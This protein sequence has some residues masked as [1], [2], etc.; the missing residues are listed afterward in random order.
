[1]TVKH[2]IHIRIRRVAVW[3]LDKCQYLQFGYG[4][5]Y[6]PDDTLRY[7]EWLWE[8][9]AANPPVPTRAERW[10]LD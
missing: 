1:M 3:T 4:Y 8:H 9:S 6:R 2:R 5:Y 10:W 7:R